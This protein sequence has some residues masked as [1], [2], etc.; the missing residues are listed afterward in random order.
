MGF[1]DP[2]CFGG[3]V[4]MA[5]FDRL[6]QGGLRYNN[7]HTA[8]VC[9][10][11]RV[12]LLTGR[13]SHSANM[14]GVAE[15]GTAFPGMTCVRPN[16]IAPLAEILRLNGDG[17]AMFG[18]SHELPPWEL[19]VSGRSTAGRRTPASTSSTGFSRASPTSTHRPS[20]TA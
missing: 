15:M 6:A 12:A 10:P 3:Q 8:P 13:N 17:T 5:A 20:T 14:G 4:D 16:S 7:F 9:S 18:K 1:G 2:S 19:S 11:T